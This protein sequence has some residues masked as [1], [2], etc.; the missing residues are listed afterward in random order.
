MIKISEIFYS[1]QGESTKAGQLCTF[2]RLAGCNLRCKWCDTEYAINDNDAKLFSVPE[3]IEKV[4]QYNCNFVEITGGEPLIQNESKVL[5][6]ELAELGYEVAIETNG[7]VLLTGLDAKI[8]KVM[9]IKCPS[10]GMNKNNLY[11]NV[12]YLNKKDE[13]KF[14]IATENDFCWSIEV[15][16][17]HRLYEKV[18]NILFSAVSTEIMYNDLAELI[19]AIEDK[20]IKKV[21]RMQLQLHKIIWG[22]EKGR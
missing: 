2:I 9:D 11:E 21:V 3:I 16:K 6:N 13:I 10:S 20:A 14:V 1:L 4:K 15:I 7:S 19:L 12:N 8:I 5:A 17:K 18:D 22:N